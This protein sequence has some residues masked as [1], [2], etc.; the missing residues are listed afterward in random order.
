VEQPRTIAEQARTIAELRA[1]N[2]RL[3]ARVA[4]LERRLGRNS[5]DSSLPPSA[6]VFTRPTKLPTT[7]SG[8]R[9]GGQPGAGGGGPAMMERPDA[10]DDHPPPA[11]IGCGGGLGLAATCWSSSTSRSS[12]PRSSVKPTR[13]L[14]VIGHLLHADESTTRIGT[15]PRWLHV[16]CTDRTRS[17]AEPP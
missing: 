13:A 16:A 9:R 5:G 14:L 3:T 12:G 8:R 2:E 7:K 1:E 17:R 6:D 10:V 15:G 11:C 4:E